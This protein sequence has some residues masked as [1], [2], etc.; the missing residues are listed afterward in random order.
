MKKLL[1]LLLMTIGISSMYANEYKAHYE[2]INTSAAKP[3]KYKAYYEGQYISIGITKT[4]AKVGT[5]IEVAVSF[6]QGFIGYDF[7]AEEAEIRIPTKVVPV[8]HYV[9]IYR[10]TGPK[11]ISAEVRGV[12]GSETI[13]ISLTITK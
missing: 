5:V 11:T 1:L 8:M 12:N 6:K 4:T 9:L 10:T 3:D 7:V 13:N 2:D